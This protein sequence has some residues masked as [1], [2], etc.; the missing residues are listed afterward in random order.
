MMRYIKSLSILLVFIVVQSFGQ[1]DFLFIP[2]GGQWDERVQ[3]K[4]D[5]QS[6][7]LFLEENSL[8]FSF[9]DNS[10]FHNLHD[11]ISD[12]V[13]HFHA[14]RLKFLGSNEHPKI[15]LLNK[16][17]GRYNYFLGKNPSKWAS[18]LQGGFTMKYEKLYDGIDLVLYTKEGRIKYEFIVH[19]GAD[20]KQ[21]KVAYEGVEPDLVRDGSLLIKTT[22]NEI[23]DLAPVS[24]QADTSVKISTSFQLTGGVLSYDVKGSYNSKD[25][26]II[27]PELV[28]STYSGSNANNFGFTATYDNK[29]FLYAG[30]SVFSQGYPITTG[31]FDV[32]FNS[33]PPT[34]SWGVSDIGISKYDTSGT[35]LIYSTYIG[36]SHTELPHSL[37]VNNKDE[38]YI[39][40]TTGSPDYPITSGA[41]DNTFAGGTPINLANGIFVNYDTGTDIIISHLNADGTAMLGSTYY[42]GTANDG[43]NQNLPANYA[44]Q[45][46]GEI[47]LDENEDV[48]V[49]TSTFS[50]DI[51]T[52]SGAL[53][54]AIGGGQDGLVFK[55]DKTLTSSIWSTYYGGSGDDA[56]YS[57][58]KSNDNNFFV[59]GGTRSL[60]LSI[61]AGAAYQNAFLGG[62]S[63]GFLSKISSDGS[64][65][66]EGTYLGSDAYDQIYFVREDNLGF[67]YVFGQS[68]KFGSYWIN[69]ATYGVANSGQFITKFDANLSGVEWS[70]SFGSGNGVINISPTAFMVDLCNQVYLSG[71]G[72]NSGGFNGVGPHVALGT[73]GMEVTADAFQS[74]TNGSDF[75]LMVLKDDASAI[76]YG[77]FYGGN[78]SSEH[79]DGG[80]SRFDRK[81]VMYQSVCAGCAYNSDFPIKPVNAVS[82]T[83]NSICNNGVFKFD[84]N[85]PTIVADFIVP[86]PG[87]LDTAYQFVNNSKILDATT[88]SW[89][90]GDGVISTDKNP[91]HQYSDSG[92][93]V[94]KLII[95]DLTSCNFIDSI[96]KTFTIRRSQRYIEALDTTCFGDSLQIAVKTNFKVGSLFNWSPNGLFS[97][98]TI[99]NPKVFIDTTQVLQLIAR[100]DPGCYDTLAYPVFV[101]QYD[102]NPIDVNAC[103]GGSTL[104][105]IVKNQN[106]TDYEWSSNLAFSDQL[107]SSTNDSSFYFNP[108][109]NDTVFYIKVTDVNSCDFIDSLHVNA[110]DFQLSIS[111]D[112]IVCH[113]TPIQAMVL[114]H[115]QYE[116]DSIA[117]FP[118]NSII[119]R[120]DSVVVNLGIYGYLS[121]YKIFARDTFGCVAIDSIRIVDNSLNLDLNDTTVCAGD[122]AQLGYVLDY[123]PLY[124]YEWFPHIVENKDSLFTQFVPVDTTVLTLVV[125][126]SF[127]IDSVKQVI[128]VNKI[129]ISTISD[130]V[131]CNYSGNVQFIANGV[132]S[133]FYLWSSN[134]FYSDSI[135]KGINERT[136]SLNPVSGES[137]IHVKAYDEFGCFDT[138]SVKIN[139]SFY[140]LTYPSDANLCFNDTALLKPNEDLSGYSGL[141]FF[142]SP[143]S[144]ILTDP[145]SSEVKVYPGPG[146]YLINV[147]SISD[148][149]CE[150]FDTIRLKISSLD[151]ALIS[152]TVN[153]QQIIKGE[154]ALITALPSS[155]AY[156]LSPWEIPS[157][158]QG[159][160][161]QVYPDQTTA[162]LVT[163]Y[164]SVIP[165][166][167]ALATVSVEVLDFICGPPYIYVPNAFT[168]NSDG[169]NDVL[170][171]RGKN[172]TK[173]YF[174]VF[175]RWGEKVFETEDQT[176]GWDGYF[177]GMQVD[178]AVY[179]F[180]LR[181]EC[182]GGETYFKKGNVTLIR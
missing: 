136:F 32:T 94:V 76:S 44:D 150:D 52:S 169:E 82:P 37:I 101:P 164:D 31:A 12:S 140:N 132:D 103:I 102:L 38:L 142:W 75:Y 56:I 172:I 143:S 25:T 179:D 68:N 8:M 162:Y 13:I 28:F 135:L 139:K 151:T 10:F 134:A 167:S 20:Y 64:S 144:N 126:N 61:N 79:V 47:F 6:G 27:D 4:V 160:Q 118:I 48:V 163:V 138:S 171:V 86:E 182:V 67:V 24:F 72:S 115:G 131:L 7:A 148:L 170:Y 63:D 1:S 128:S 49:A 33:N 87:C 35:K 137:T 60:D 112:T 54:T 21:I 80:T 85:I 114:S 178:P 70:T 107:N 125:N 2:N 74:F 90:F 92:T 39:F 113:Q 59:A 95:S 127:C 180:Y 58:I 30:G 84:F 45:I 15:L 123:N 145:S 22:V 93:Y 157:F 181:S 147:K 130:T 91:T 99:L 176:I 155:F 173:M 98:D 104:L 96:S 119:G 177:K 23:I 71:W 120:T 34:G 124:T 116:L 19:P 108:V 153:P 146:E 26:L 5:L 43:L 51:P 11:G 168:P 65:F 154:F 77:S 152:A 159:N 40:G 174:A 97:K 81:G 55:L 62:Y 69:N 17:S 149:G 158:L 110:I 161:F 105:S 122:T 57:L 50:T 100:T 106:F 165:N 41:F 88:Y 3:Y 121:D 117:W 42:G 156:K 66:L 141:K 175:D 16:K 18:N 89:D 129:E 36:G 109:T 73:I 14:Y 133:L 78:L 29:G 9:Y 83:N 111:K 46:R 166:C 53:Q